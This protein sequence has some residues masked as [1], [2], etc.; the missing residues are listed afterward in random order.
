MLY[1]IVVLAIFYQFDYVPLFEYVTYSFGIS[2]II[3]QTAMNGL[4]KIKLKLF[5][6]VTSH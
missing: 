2:I 1:F 5:T 3:I 4:K 6:I